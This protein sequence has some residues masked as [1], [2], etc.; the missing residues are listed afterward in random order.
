[1]CVYVY[2]C[3]VIERDRERKTREGTIVSFSRF[4]MIFSPLKFKNLTIEHVKIE[5]VPFHPSLRFAP[6]LSFIAD[7]K[8]L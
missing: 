2:A 7:S 1:M 6:N 4:Q 5:I 3:D 8:P